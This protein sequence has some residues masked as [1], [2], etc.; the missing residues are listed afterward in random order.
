MELLHSSREVYQFLFQDASGALG[1]PGAPWVSQ[2]S[3]LGALGSFDNPRSQE[4]KTHGPACAL[5][6]LCAHGAYRAPSLTSILFGWY[7]AR[8]YIMALWALWGEGG[9]TVGGWVVVV[10]TNT[11]EDDN[12][13]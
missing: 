10:G 12:T 2:N 1:G 9:W 11:K 5:W 13:T 4:P 8:F 3:Y 7:Y 6:A